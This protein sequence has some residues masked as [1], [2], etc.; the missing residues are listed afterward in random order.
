MTLNHEYKKVL[1]VG[2]NGANNTGSEARLLSIINDIQE[3]LGSNVIIT[4]PTLNEKNLRRY[5][6]ESPNI[7]IQAIPSIFHL[8]LI[9]LVKKNDLILLVEGSCYMDTW[10]SALLTAFL[11]TTKYA[12]KYNKPCVAYAVDAGHLSPSNMKKVKNDASKTSLI[13][14]RTYKAAEILQSIG[15]TAPMKVTADCAFRFNSQKDDEQI[16]DKIWPVDN[17]LVGFAVVDFHLWPVKMRLWGK[18]EYCYKWPYYFSRSPEDKKSSNLLAYR[19]A[20]RADEIIEEHDKKIALICME[21]VD[22]P[23]ARLILEKIRNKDQAQIFSS[24]RYNASQMTGILQNLDLLITSR[25]H[26]GVLSLKKT[27][28]QIAVGHDTRLR[29]FYD[30]LGIYDKYFIDYKK[31]DAWKN[32]KK[33]S[34]E[35]IEKPDNLKY[36]LKKG[37]VNHLERARENPLLLEKFIKERNI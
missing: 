21:D 17:G 8:A 25:Y 26:A 11:W 18:S 35:L 28:P 7:K 23:L 12:Y 31:S 32:I 13:I 19:W 6:K 37:F 29:T 2:Y 9:S 30:E 20:V 33:I 27:V 10:S 3:L 22:I 36:I 14:T 4:I 24:S 16:L 1:L 5:I 15:V 34:D